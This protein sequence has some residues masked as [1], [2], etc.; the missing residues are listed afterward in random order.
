MM[1]IDP[2][3]FVSTRRQELLAEADSMRLAAQLPRRRS[4]ARHGLAVACYR[5][6]NWLEAPS[7]YLRASDSGPED[8]ASP[9]ANA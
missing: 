8:W 4:S 7:R 5:L 3:M 6:A 9:W 2:A 1:M